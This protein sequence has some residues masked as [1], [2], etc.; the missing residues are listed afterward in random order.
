MKIPA[1]CA[2]K[3]M[4][5]RHETCGTFDL[6]IVDGCVGVFWHRQVGPERRMDCVY[7]PTLAKALDWIDQQI[8]GSGAV[9]AE[10]GP[11]NVDADGRPVEAA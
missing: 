3:T 8:A 4:E 1:G 7:V 2:L 5:L 11:E 6:S 10:A 9:L